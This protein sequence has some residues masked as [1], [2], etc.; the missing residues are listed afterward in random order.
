MVSKAEPIFKW[1]VSSLEHRLS[2]GYVVRPYWRLEG[3][4]GA[5]TVYRSGSL[6]FTDGE[7]SI[8]YDSITEDLAVSWVTA[9]IGDS[10]VEDLKKSIKDEL[11]EL[12][13]P[14]VAFGLPWIPKVEAAVTPNV[15]VLNFVEGQSAI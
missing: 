9:H 1:S 4:Q 13:N 6:S 11:N 7:P 2:D 15:T 3:T 12:I 8:P 5:F 10:G 14:V